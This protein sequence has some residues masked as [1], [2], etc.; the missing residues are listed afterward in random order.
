VGGEVPDNLGK[1]K[2]TRKAKRPT[3][4]GGFVGLKRESMNALDEDLGNQPALWRL[5]FKLL[6]AANYGKGYRGE[7][8]F[9]ENPWSIADIASCVN[10]CEGAVRRDLHRLEKIGLLEQLDTGATLPLW[11]VKHYDYFVHKKATT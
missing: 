4:P 6:A 3:Y 11:T 9:P 1:C 10:L 2:M 8:G 7:L 5:Y